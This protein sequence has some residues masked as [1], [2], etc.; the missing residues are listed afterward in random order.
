MHGHLRNVVLLL[1]AHALVART[2]LIPIL[3]SIT[4]FRP[5]NAN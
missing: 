1:R 4:C 2:C 5:E 3:S